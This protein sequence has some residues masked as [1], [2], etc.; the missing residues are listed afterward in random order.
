MAVTLC[1][2]PHGESLS[3]KTMLSENVANPWLMRIAVTL[4]SQAQGVAKLPTKLENPGGLG[5][6]VG[7]KPQ[8]G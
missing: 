6:K 8:S 7:V 4:C 3:P 1:S 2:Q 5:P